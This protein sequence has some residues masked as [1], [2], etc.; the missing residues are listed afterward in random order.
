MT[1]RLE[2]AI[3]PSAWAMALASPVTGEE[4]S[5]SAALPGGGGMTVSTVGY[6][7]SVAKQVVGVLAARSVLDRRLD[8]ESP[9][10]SVLPDLPSWLDPVRVRHLLAHTAALPQPE[11]LAGVLGR[12][13]DLAGW[14][15]L[16]NADVRT[17]LHG[18]PGPLGPPG[19]AHSYDNTGYV[20]LAEVVAATDGRPIEVLAAELFAATGMSSTRLGG[21]RPVLLPGEVPPP[22]TVGDGGLW[23]TADD[24]LR[25]LRSLNGDA[26][27]PEVGA[28][29]ATPWR[30]DDGTAVDY[31][32]GIGPRS[33]PG[34]TTAFLHGGSW[35]GWAAMTARNPDVGTAVAVLAVAEDAVAVQVAAV[36]VHDRLQA[37]V[38]S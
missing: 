22:R 3:A 23:T 25:W 29:I 27:G 10:R 11:A 8:V 24:L 36:E 37:A 18:V 13:G 15:T 31:A 9:V 17:A 1:I 12:P 26:F 28:L 32:W 7:A 30:L 5:A 6:A 19:R 14:S 34:G 35:P 33:A 2:P 21:E 16:A 38:R 4:R 20:L